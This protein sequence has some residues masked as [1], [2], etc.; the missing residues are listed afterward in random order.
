VFEADIKFDENVH[1][2]EVRLP[3]LEKYELLNDNLEN[4]KRRMK[5]LLQKFKSNEELLHEY[6][7]IIKEQLE[8][9]IIELPEG[10]CLMQALRQMVLH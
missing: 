7:T 8:L 10:W 3:F 1:R 4:S 2:Y 9:G 5:G 6:D